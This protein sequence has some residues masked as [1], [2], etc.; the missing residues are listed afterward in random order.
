M[1]I[2]HSLKNI[3]PYV[4]WRRSRRDRCLGYSRE[5][6]I[7]SCELLVVLD[8]SWDWLKSHFNYKR[9]GPTTDISYISHLSLKFGLVRTR[10]GKLLTMRFKTTPSGSSKTR[11]KVGTRIWIN[12]LLEDRQTSEPLDLNMNLLLVLQLERHQLDRRVLSLGK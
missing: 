5:F 12:S 1:G 10:F 9:I 4:R 3:F 8:R 2:Y 11:V 6:V 7:D